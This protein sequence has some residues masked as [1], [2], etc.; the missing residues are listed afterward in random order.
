MSS[1]AV[2]A[3]PSLARQAN[4]IVGDLTRPKPWV[5]W[6]D[7]AATA[8]ILYLSLFLAATLATPALVLLAAAIAVLA[9]YRAISFIHELTHLRPGAVPGFH[10]GWNALIGAPF[11]TPSLMYEGVHMLHHAKDR[12]GTHED[13]EYRPLARLPAR[14]LALFLGIAILAPLGVYLRFAVIAPLSLLIPPLRRLATGRL[15][16]MT[17]NPAFVRR[18]LER[19]RTQ[20]WLAQ[21]IACWLWSWALTALTAAHVI[22]GRVVLTAAAVYAVMAALNQVRTAVA[23][24]W[25][26]EGE[27]MSFRDQFL[28]TVNV[29][30]PALLPM[31]WAP[32]GLRYHALHHLMPRLPYHNLAAAHRRLVATLPADSDYRRV[33]QR[34]LAPAMA[35]L[36]RR[37]RSRDLTAA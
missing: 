5:Y 12:Y 35:R 36:V 8:L 17:I 30:P 32:V 15:S 37:M 29:P 16:A 34:E 14:Q 31:L 18:D 19:A 22:P 1:V 26:S 23:H 13:P 9:L 33:E 6:C 4:E 27:R 28:D 2:T 21:E 11:L 20:A 7:L 24:A 10:L 25:E 3:P